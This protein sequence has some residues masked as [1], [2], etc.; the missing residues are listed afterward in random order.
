[1]ASEKSLDKQKARISTDYMIE[2]DT[3]VMI[4]VTNDK[5]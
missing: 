1:V 5:K 2:G 4:Q 3:Q